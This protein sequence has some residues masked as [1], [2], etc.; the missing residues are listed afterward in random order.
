MPEFKPPARSASV[1]DLLEAATAV[2]RMTLAKGLPLGMFAVLLVAMPNIYWLTKGKPVDILAPPTDSTFWV[3]TGLGFAGYQLLAAA[4]LLRQRALLSARAPDLRQELAAASARWWVLVVSVVLAGVVMFAGLL[5]LVLPGVYAL[6]CLLLLRPVVM[7][8]A[9]D[10]LQAL[11]RCFALVRPIWIK[12]MASALIAA[13]IFMICAFMATICL[14]LAQSLLSL[15][16]VQAAALSALA[17]ACILGLQAV[18]MVFFNALWLV[19]Y[20]TASS[21]A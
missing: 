16:G 7:F 13:L 14:S 18:A 21:S 4:L 6:V 2:F 10:P 1:S 17:A 20:S 8:E 12:V 15:A 3:L 11:L 9:R 19:L 5:M